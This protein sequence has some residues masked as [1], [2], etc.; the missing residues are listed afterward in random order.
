MG[1]VTERI[2]QRISEEHKRFS[3]NADSDY[4]HGKYQAYGKALEIIDEESAKEPVCEWKLLD[5]DNN[6]Y[7]TECGDAFCIP[8]GTPQE[9][10]MNYCSCC[11]RKVKVVE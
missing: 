5:A 6:A 4:Y 2:K 1:D 3:F 7:Q 9:N 11:G 8:D 10:N